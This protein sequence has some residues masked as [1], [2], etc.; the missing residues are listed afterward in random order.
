MLFRSDEHAGAHATVYDFGIVGPTGTDVT[1][2]DEGS[3]A[4]VWLPRP[5]AAEVALGTTVTVGQGPGS[6]RS[7]GIYLL[8]LT[9]RQFRRLVEG[10]GAEQYPVA[11]SPD[12]RY[13]LYSTVEAQGVCR[14]A[15]VDADAP[16]AGTV[17]IN[18]EITFCGL[19]GHVVGW[20]EL[21]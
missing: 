16:D 7:G 5:G 19:N 2:P 6:T 10:D 12:G 4:A 1:A 21:P 17:A 14:F 15:Y 11:W 18:E 3:N 8:D 9:T 13:L 20:T